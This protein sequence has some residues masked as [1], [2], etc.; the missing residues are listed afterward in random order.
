VA[1]AAVVAMVSGDAEIIEVGATFKTRAG[2][3]QKVSNAAFRHWFLS[4]RDAWVLFK[5]A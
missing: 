5:S 4:D 3:H 1:A 2:P